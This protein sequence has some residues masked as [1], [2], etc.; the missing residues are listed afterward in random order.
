MSKLRS[1]LSWLLAGILALT[2]AGCGG[3]ATVTPPPTYGADEI[4]QIQKYAPSI[5][6]THERFDEL[7]TAIDAANW[8][9]TQNL[10][11]GPFGQML[12]DMNY[13]SLHLLPEDQKVARQAS[14]SIFEDFV[15]IDRAAADNNI[16]AAARAYDQVLTDFEQFVQVV[17]EAALAQASASEVTP[18]APKAAEATPE[19]AP[20]PVAESSEV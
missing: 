13:L 7:L 10:M 18:P 6:A 14:R 20:E 2:I 11:R 17:P 4:T 8:T 1:L 12:Q 3:S 5:L 19:S 16:D 9:E 15:R